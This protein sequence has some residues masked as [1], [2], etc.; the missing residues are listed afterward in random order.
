M[1]LPIAVLF[2]FT[3]LPS[4]MAAPSVMTGAQAMVTAEAQESPGTALVVARGS[5]VDRHLS[6]RFTV[7]SRRHTT[8]ACAAGQRAGARVRIGTREIA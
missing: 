8:D 1:R 5:E 4:A 2:L 7:L 6:E 3:G